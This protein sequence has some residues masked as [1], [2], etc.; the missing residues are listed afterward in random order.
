MAGGA[1][2]LGARPDGGAAPTDFGGSWGGIGLYGYLGQQGQQSGLIVSRVDAN[3]PAGQIGLIAGDII[4]E[5][6][7]QD[8]NDMTTRQ[9]Q[10]LFLSL[11]TE[12]KEAVTMQVWNSHTRRTSTLKAVFEDK[13]V[14]GFDDGE[15]SDDP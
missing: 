7:D 8:I 13:A 11:T 3:S 2:Y 15:V 14:E 9:L 5:I 10:V 6:N 1:G 12:L 4:L